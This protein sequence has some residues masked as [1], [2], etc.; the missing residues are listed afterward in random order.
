MRIRVL[1]VLDLLAD[2]MTAQE[3]TRQLP[4]L[5]EDDIRASLIYAARAVGSD[6]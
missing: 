1:D 5:E 4:A 2:G 3:I 6:N